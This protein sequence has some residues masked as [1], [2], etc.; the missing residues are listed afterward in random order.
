VRDLKG[1]IR[2]RDPWINPREKL[3]CMYDR[4]RWLQEPTNAIINLR[5]ARAKARRDSTMMLSRALSIIITRCENAK[6]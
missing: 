3:V 4:V 5:D 2:A 6:S 1:K